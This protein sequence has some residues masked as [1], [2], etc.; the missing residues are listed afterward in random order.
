[1]LRET[2]NVFV[3]AILFWRMEEET[4]VEIASVGSNS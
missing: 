4:S 3:R 1:M 2:F